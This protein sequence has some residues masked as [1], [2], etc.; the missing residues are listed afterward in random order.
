MCLSKFFMQHI[1]INNK[2]FSK[3]MYYPNTYSSITDI[4]E[5]GSPVLSNFSKYFQNDTHECFSNNLQIS[6]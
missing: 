5:V 4:C 1:N 3:T 2:S 6:L